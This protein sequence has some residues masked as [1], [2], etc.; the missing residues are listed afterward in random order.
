[1]VKK[2]TFYGLMIA[3][4]FIFSYIESLI[5]IFVTIPGIKL[6]LSNIITVMI[7]ISSGPLA[8]IWISIVRIFLVSIT[9]GNLSLLLYSIAGALL[10][11]LLMILLYKTKLFDVITVSIAGAVGHNVGQIL[12]AAYLISS[13]NLFYYLPILIISAIITGGLI[14]FIVKKIS[15]RIKNI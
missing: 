1:M 15:K 11:L 12:L 7:L 13:F 2:T 9:F 6:G 5:P 3:L 4:A 14:G 8:A 10:S